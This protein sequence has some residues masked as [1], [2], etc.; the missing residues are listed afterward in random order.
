MALTKWEIEKQLET[1][2]LVWPGGIYHLD[3]VEQSWDVI[4]VTRVVVADDQ[5]F[6][7]YS[8]L[9]PDTVY[10]EFRFGSTSIKLNGWK[11]AQAWYM[12]D[13]DGALVPQRQFMQSKGLSV[14][15]QKQVRRTREEAIE[16]FN[17]WGQ[18][19]LVRTLYE[20]RIKQCKVDLEKFNETLN[21]IIAL[22][23]KQ[24]AACD[25]WL[26]SPTLVADYAAAVEQ[27]ADNPMFTNL[28]ISL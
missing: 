20:R 16:A 3:Y 24:S 4:L 26:A 21:K 9:H 25:A 12:A 2:A 5:V 27:V 1:E 17:T 7:V 10:K 19:H 11:A 15:S 18:E 28:P 14:V 23:T 13:P 22:V 6:D 8:P